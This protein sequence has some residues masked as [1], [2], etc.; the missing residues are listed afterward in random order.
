MTFVDYCLENPEEKPDIDEWVDRWHHGDG[1]EGQELWDFLGFTREEY[2][3]WVRD[4]S[5]E[6]K[7][8]AARRYAH[9]Q[10]PPR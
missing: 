5:Y 2:G 7:I 3:E 8:I 1:A 4:L 6:A 9:S 10:A